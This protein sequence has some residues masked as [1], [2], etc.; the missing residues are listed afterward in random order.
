MTSTNVARERID[1]IDV[2]RGVA[3]LSVACFYHYQHFSRAFQSNSTGNVPPFYSF[4]PF[5]ILFER[6][7]L[8]VDVFFVLSG[9]I[10]VYTYRKAVKGRLVS[11]RDFFIRRFSRLY[12]IHLLMLLFTTL[13]VNIYYFQ[14]KSFPLPWKND[15]F[16]FILNVLFVQKGFFDEGFSFNGPSWSLSI[17]MFMYVIFYIQS[18]FLK[19]IPSSIILIFIGVIFFSSSVHYKFLFNVEMGRGLIGFF[20]GCLLYEFALKDNSV[21]KWYVL[22]LAATLFFVLYIN[23]IRFYKTM[24]VN[25]QLI[26]FLFIIIPCIHNN[27]NIQKVM[28]IKWLRILG[29]ISLSMYLVHVPIQ[30]VIIYYFKQSTITIPYNSPMLFLSYCFLVLG[31]SYFLHKS[32]EKPIQAKIRQLTP[33]KQ[34]VQQSIT[35]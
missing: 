26:G 13:I 9:I 17:E 1:Y 31:V 12:P 14:F 22:P 10:F 25:F 34:I 33:P 18:R 11:G 30:M 8:M 24:P 16:H 3:A 27:K 28:N 15:C 21:F 19:L 2:I 23:Y 32:F 6:G 20:G 29:D 7:D 35:S 4:A 5:R